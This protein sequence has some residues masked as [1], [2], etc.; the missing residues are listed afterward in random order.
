MSLPGWNSL[1]ST[2]TLHNFIELGGIALFLVVVALS[3]WGTS[4]VT[5]GTS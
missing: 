1:E 4:L 5:A 3:S 2:T